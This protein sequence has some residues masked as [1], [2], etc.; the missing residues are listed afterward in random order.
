M[1]GT[2]VHCAKLSAQGLG[3]CAKLLSSSEDC[4][5][6]LVRYDKSDAVSGNRD[7]DDA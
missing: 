6:L 2:L 5:T 4:L 3:G 1:P 7:G